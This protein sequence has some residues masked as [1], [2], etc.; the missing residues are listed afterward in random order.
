MNEAPLP[1]PRAHA[2]EVHVLA[3]RLG[4]AAQCCRDV[5]ALHY[6]VRG[7]CVVDG[8]D[9]PCRTNRLIDEAHVLDGSRL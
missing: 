6:Y 9:E 8:D 1:T 7:R 2:D 5:K 4:C 3:D